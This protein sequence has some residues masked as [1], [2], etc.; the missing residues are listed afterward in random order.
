MPISD[1]TKEQLEQYAKES[2]NC[3][4]LMIKC[5]YTNFGCPRYLTPFHLK[6]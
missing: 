3:K 6:C 1:L 2:T 5:G 4:E